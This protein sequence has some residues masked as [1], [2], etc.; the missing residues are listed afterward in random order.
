MRRDLEQLICSKTRNILTSNPD[1]RDLLLKKLNSDPSSHKLDA[2]LGGHIPPDQFKWALS[3]YVDFLKQRYGSFDRIE[4]MIPLYR[5]QQY[6]FKPADE[7]SPLMYSAIKHISI[8]EPWQSIKTLFRNYHKVKLSYRIRRPEQRLHSITFVVIEDQTTTEIAYMEVE[9]SKRIIV[10]QMA[11]LQLAESIS[12]KYF[13]ALVYLYLMDIPPTN[14][15]H[16]DMLNQMTSCKV[17]G[18]PEIENRNKLIFD[19][20][21]DSDSETESCLIG[22]LKLQ[23]LK[24]PDQCQSYSMNS[25]L[26]KKIQRFNQLAW[27]A[28]A[29]L[30]NDSK[31]SN[32]TLLFNATNT[33]R[34]R[35]NITMEFDHNSSDSQQK[36][37]P[38]I[39][40]KIEAK[41]YDVFNLANQPPPILSPDSI[42]FVC[43]E[44]LS[45]V[46]DFLFRKYNTH[47]KNSIRFVEYSQAMQDMKTPLYVE[48]YYFN[49][50][51]M[52]RFKTLWKNCLIQHA[53]KA[54]TNSISPVMEKDVG[55]AHI[56][57]KDAAKNLV[58]ARL[59]AYRSAFVTLPKDQ[60]EEF[61]YLVAVGLKNIRFLKL[62]IEFFF[63]TNINEF[64][65]L[66]DQ[67]YAEFFATTTV[68][69]ADSYEPLMNYL[70]ANNAKIESIKISCSKNMLLFE[71]PRNSDTV[72]SLEYFS[73]LNRY[74]QLFFREP[75]SKEGV[76]ENGVCTLSRRINSKFDRSF[77]NF[78]IALSSNKSK[79]HHF[80]LAALV[81][82]YVVF[83]DFRVRNNDW[84]IET[85]SKIALQFP[86]TPA[87][88]TVRLTDS[89]IHMDKEK[90]VVIANQYK[91]VKDMTGLTAVS[92]II[93]KIL[94][95]PFMIKAENCESQTFI[96]TG[97][98]GMNILIKLKVMANN[99]REA[100]ATFSNILDQLLY[101]PCSFTTN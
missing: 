72:K 62:L 74:I 1:R 6:A 86:Q 18:P 83:E 63:S 58:L 53:A 99:Q 98:L 87:E 59:H 36:I 11:A 80:N 54:C 38:V 67:E 79:D 31:F 35:N 32:S 78:T 39:P 4:E 34:Y 81:L 73:T 46:D 14:D 33:K 85:A 24:Q 101:N 91:K 52:V 77:L 44:V 55:N 8:E 76:F 51:L 40:D 29:K 100:K 15:I 2:F 43:E 70:A 75:L 68:E 37:V 90:M 64:G 5:L 97:T 45:L 88:M 19:A 25:Y 10:I 28:N 92:N 66:Y 16:E 65:N 12:P 47:I 13:R 95:T 26:M 84:I 7:A 42:G 21:N 3:S 23:P 9:T 61:L 56:L 94:Q 17:S 49:E 41:L 96:V 20:R 50:D 82:L 57:F 22:D 27:E 93:N 71:L 89:I 30:S 48:K 60:F 69:S